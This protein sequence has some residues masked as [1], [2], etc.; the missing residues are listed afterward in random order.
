M[1]ERRGALVLASSGGLAGGCAR[2]L[3]AAGSGVTIF[4]RSA[5]RLQT[6]AQ[7]ISQA[8]GTVVVESGDVANDLDI[9]RAVDSTLAEFGQL[10]TLVVNAPGPPPGRFLDLTLDQWDAAWTGTMRSAIVAITHC[11]PHMLERRY[12]RIIV[13]GSSSVR[14]PLPNLMLSNA[15][16]PGINGM[17]KALAV[18][19]ADQGITVNMACPGRIQT[20]RVHAIDQL[21]ADREGVSLGEVRRRSEAQI[22]AGRYGTIAEFAALVAFLASD[23]ASYITGQTLLADGGLAATL[24]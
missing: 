4:S 17:V 11:L 14:R 23:E 22:P 19:V 7:E 9:S 8:G 3:A 12:G 6:L 1:V 2:A 24:P 20:P 13:I 10:A 21:A 18:E 16:R 5:D 15:F